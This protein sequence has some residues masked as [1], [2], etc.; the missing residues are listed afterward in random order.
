MTRK[1]KLIVGSGIWLALF[2]GA[3]CLWRFIIRDDGRVKMTP[4]A[5]RY[6]HSNVD[7]RDLGQVQQYAKKF[8]YNDDYYIIC[9]F[10]KRSGLKRFYVYDL[11]DKKI[12][13][14]SY[15][16]HGAGSGST[17]EKPV[18]SNKPGSN[19]SSLGLYA[20]CGIGTK[21][22]KNSIRLE[23]FDSTNNRARERGILIH[24]AGVVTRFKGDQDYLPIDAKLSQGCFTIE[25]PVV[26]SLIKIYKRHGRHKRILMWAYC[27]DLT[28]QTP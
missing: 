7:P 28:E 13:T 26:S 6:W 17:P 14:Q 22:M 20:L 16:M 12:I 19:A 23:G 1:Q 8:G 25:F 5:L 18:F 10:G 2:L 15:C 21:K 11:N 27:D 4:A 9:D 3:R 24:S